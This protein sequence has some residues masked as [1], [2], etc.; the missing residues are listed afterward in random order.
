MVNLR[1]GLRIEHQR[2]L[3][4][5]EEEK[6][7]RTKITHENEEVECEKFDRI[8]LIKEKLKDMRDNPEHI[9]IRSKF[10]ILH[11]VFMK[12]IGDVLEELGIG[13]LSKA[14]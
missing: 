10:P 4:S 13:G 11:E 12:P 14:I 3:K 7:S 1:N 8:K 6:N 5:M 9:G 2:R